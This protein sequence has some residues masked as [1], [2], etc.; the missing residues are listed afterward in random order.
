MNV[1]F[2]GDDS[3]RVERA[4][5]RKWLWWGFV[6]GVSFGREGRGMNA[7]GESAKNGLL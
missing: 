1:S 5:C 4:S 7:E 2:G 3:A 6:R